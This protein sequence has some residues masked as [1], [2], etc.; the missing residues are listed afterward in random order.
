MQSL[1]I[2]LE[3]VIVV[4]SLMTILSGSLAFFII[5]SHLISKHQVSQVK[6]QS[7]V[8][9]YQT[10]IQ[11]LQSDIQESQITIQDHQTIILKLQNQLK[12]KDKRSWQ[13]GHNSAK[14]GLAEFLAFLGLSIAQK[15]DIICM[16]ASSSKKPSV[17]AIG[18]DDE[19]II[20]LEFKKKGVTLSTKE[21]KIR[22]LIEEKKVSYQ[23]VDVNLPENLTEFRDYPQKKEVNV[24]H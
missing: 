12:L 10:K 11:E 6:V 22:K 8:E 21:N 2:S 9:N 3:I 5:R 17:D 16:L 14:G 18:F 7:V 24:C 20:F 15:F 19:Q 4:I 1:E 23:R 13:V